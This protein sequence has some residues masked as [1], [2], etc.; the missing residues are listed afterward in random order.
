MN[1]GPTQVAGSFVEAL[2]G[3]PLSLALVAMN[4]GL[5]GFL[6]YTGVVAAKERHMEM[7]LMYENRSEVAKLLAACYPTGPK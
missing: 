6:Y 5:L 7:K 4:L 3:Q 1:N 2:R